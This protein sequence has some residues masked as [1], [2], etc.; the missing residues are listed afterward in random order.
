MSLKVGWL[1]RIALR[2]SSV[3]KASATAVLQ[4]RLQLKWNAL[5]M[6]SEVFRP[7]TASLY[8]VGA[9]QPVHSTTL[10]VWLQSRESPMHSR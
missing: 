2:C 6:Q 9:V 4:M 10:S 7:G 8:T 1:R 5:L 3:I